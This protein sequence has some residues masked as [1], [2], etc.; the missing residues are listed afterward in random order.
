MCCRL[1]LHA[2]DQACVPAARCHL[3]G[4]RPPCSGPAPPGLW[5]S[6][7]S[8][9]QALSPIC[10]QAAGQLLI[11]TASFLAMLYVCLKDWLCSK[12]D[13]VTCLSHQPTGSAFGHMFTACWLACL[14]AYFVAG[15]ASMHHHIVLC[16]LHDCLPCLHAISCIHVCM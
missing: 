12:L 2:D 10:C 15:H 6:Q 7:L 5:G 8:P 16:H 1:W 4:C 11:A 13:F 3:R 9:L 14:L